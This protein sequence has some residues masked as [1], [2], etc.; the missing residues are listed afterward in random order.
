VN[1]KVHID[2]LHILR[3]AFAGGEG[4]VL[5]QELVG[6]PLERLS[7]FELACP[8]LAFEAKVPV[9]GK[10]LGKSQAV[11]LRRDTPVPARKIR[12]STA[13]GC[14]FPGDRPEAFLLTRYDVPACATPYAKC[15]NCVRYV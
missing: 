6:C 14:C 7:A 12:S 2:G 10:V 4:L 9:F 5:K 13:N 11:L 15:A 3:A 8:A 1:L